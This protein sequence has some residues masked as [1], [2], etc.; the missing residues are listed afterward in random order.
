MTPYVPLG[1]VYLFKLMSSFS[2]CFSKKHKNHGWLSCTR[3]IYF[4]LNIEYSSINLN[5]RF[6]E[7]TEWILEHLS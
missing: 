6:H 2:Q 3:A 5:I 7:V 1:Y 4:L